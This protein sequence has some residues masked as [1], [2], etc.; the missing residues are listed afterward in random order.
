[1]LLVK[2]DGQERVCIEMQTAEVEELGA[3]NGAAV[4]PATGWTGGED[5]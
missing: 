5:R 1:M 4:A 2:T 3:R